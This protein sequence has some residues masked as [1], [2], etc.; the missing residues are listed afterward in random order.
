[1]HLGAT[2]SFFTSKVEK[3]S[4]ISFD[5]LGTVAST[6]SIFLQ[7]ENKSLFYSADKHFCKI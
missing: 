1:M 5:G 7:E 2:K 6:A 4:K 3:V